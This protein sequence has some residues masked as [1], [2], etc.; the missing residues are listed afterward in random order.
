V[1]QSLKI[2][3]SFIVLV[4]LATIMLSGCSSVKYGLYD[5]VISYENW[6][7]GLCDRRI[8]IDGRTIAL[9]DSGQAD[10]KQTL[11][12]IHGVTATKEHWIRFA[13]YFTDAYHVVA[14]DLPG[15]GE[16]F[17]DIN[18][19]YD[20]VDQARYLKKI[21]NQLNI[22]KCHLAGN[23]MG[24]AIAALYAAMY[25]E[26]VRSLLLFD[27]AGIHEYECE[28]TRMLK[29]GKNPLIVECAEDFDALK[30]LALE[31]KPY[32]PWPIT[33]VMAEKAVENKTIND[34]IFSDLHLDSRYDF[35]EALKKII[36]PTLILWGVEDRLISVDTAQ[37]FNRLIPHSK[38]VI[39]EGIG[40]EPMLEAPEKSAKICL[41]FISSL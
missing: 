10:K 24:G 39:L 13:A 38:K 19:N 32:I 3:R 7:A 8:E 12:L 1:K 36:A 16:S 25:P 5:M 6:K 30:D 28:L 21:L 33:S 26:K 4:L 20:F 27:P 37:V 23:S 14:I 17:K 34:K 41:N 18:L 29:A 11:V 22:Q 2:S 35:Q 40:H 15:H 9:L 31:E